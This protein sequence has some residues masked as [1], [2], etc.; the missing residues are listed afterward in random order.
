VE[1]YL[2]D[3]DEIKRGMPLKVRLWRCYY[4]G[5]PFIQVHSAVEAIRAL[6]P[7]IPAKEGR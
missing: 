7:A 2:N 3:T 6:L 4:C 1:G 5:E